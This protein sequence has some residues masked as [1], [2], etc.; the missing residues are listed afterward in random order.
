L[1]RD[2]KQLNFIPLFP[3]AYYLGV[4]RSWDGTLWV[5]GVEHMV[6][7]IRSLRLALEERRSSQTE[8]LR[9]FFNRLEQNV[10]FAVPLIHFTPPPFFNEVSLCKGDDKMEKNEKNI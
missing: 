7:L 10:Y 5:S 8:E 2:N 6:K 3:Y 1:I 9:L 4:Y